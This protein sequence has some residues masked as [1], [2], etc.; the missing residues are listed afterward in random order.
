MPRSHLVNEGYK[1]TQIRARG[2]LRFKGVL[3]M[4][5]GCL[6]L[7]VSLP[8]LSAPLCLH[9]RSGKSKLLIAT[10]SI[11]HCFLGLAR[12][13]QNV[14]SEGGFMSC[15]PAPNQKKYRHRTFLENQFWC[16][17]ITLMYPGHVKKFLL[18]SPFFVCN[19]GVSH[20]IWK[21]WGN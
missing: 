17:Y 10:D 13:E 5:K 16:H 2:L 14:E 4:T 11:S 8:F 12:E 19:P 9:A 7:S 21:L 3:N 15:P 18:G 1:M 6:R 20:K